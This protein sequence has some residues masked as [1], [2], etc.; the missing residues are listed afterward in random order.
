MKHAERKH[1][2]LS[3]SGADRWMNCTPSAR[4]EEEFPEGET[5]GFALEG[6]LAH[7]FGDTELRYF[8]GEIDLKKKNAILSVLRKNKHYSN[9]MEDQVE[10]YT[11]FV[12]ELFNVAKSKTPGAVLMVEERVD[13]SHLVEE[14]FGTSDVTIIADKEMYVVDHKYG[15]GIMVSAEENPQLMLYGSGAHRA[16]EL[17]Y[18][19]DTVKLIIMQPRLNHVSTWS[20]SVDDLLAWGEEIVKPKAEMAY[21]GE[22]KQ[23]P[24]DWCR[25][26]KVKPKCRALAE[27]NLALAKMEF[28]DPNLLSDEEVVEVYAQQGQLVEWAGAVSS[29]MTKEAQSGK[30]WDGYKLVE[31]R[32][33]RKWRNEEEIMEALKSKKY[34]RRVYINTKLKGLGDMEK[35]LGPKRFEEILSDHI[36]K[37]AGKPT[38][39]PESDKRPEMGSAESA[40]SDF[41]DN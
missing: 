32:A 27:K 40:K 39:V 25:W 13:F 21:E 18:D 29:F 22:G 4:L 16:A 10:K 20:I 2:L 19:I 41:L 24:G 35:F 6:T 26:C 37:P 9:E 31:G 14:G 33:N 28:K 1:A 8:N 5:S 30:K 34:P 23:I 15:K 36:I 7:E 3:A 11:D 38:L 12:K 17:M